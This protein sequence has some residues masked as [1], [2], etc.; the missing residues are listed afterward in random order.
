M[1]SS[2]KRSQAYRVDADPVYTRLL[3]GMAAGGTIAFGLI[4]VYVIGERLGR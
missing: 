4:L 3:W 1:Q 2:T